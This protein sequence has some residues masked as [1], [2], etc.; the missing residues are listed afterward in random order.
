MRFLL[1]LC[2]L[3]T[4][5]TIFGQDRFQELDQHFQRLNKDGYFSGNILMAEGDSILF[6]GSY[7]YADVAAKRK[8]N[9]ESVFEL[10]SVS[11]QF[12]ATGIALLAED[13]KIDLDEPVATYLPELAAYPKITVRHLVHHVG[14]LADYMEFSEKHVKR[15]EFVTNQTVLD[16]FRDK[17]PKVSFKAGDHFEYSNS[18]YLILA[19][20]IERVSEQSFGD[21][22]TARIFKPLGM[23]SSSVY[24]RRYAPRTIENYAHGHVWTGE[25]YAI[26]DSLEDLQFVVWL[27]GVVGDGM[28]NSTLDD[29]WKW[30]R[31]FAKGKLDTALLFQPGLEADSSSTGYA[32]GLGVRNHPD[33]GR[34]ISHSGGWPGYNTFTYYFPETDRTL[35][36]LRN[37]NGG[38]SG[39]IN[40]LRNSIRTLFELPLETES[41]HPLTTT[42]VDLKAAKEYVGTYAVVPEFKLKFFIKKDKFFTQATNQ[43]A[44]ELAAVPD[45]E[46]RFAI[47]EVDAEIQF[48]RD[49]KGKVT[50]LT[51]FQAGQEVP[52][53]RE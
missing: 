47:T 26:P 14:G 6:T 9:R 19:S 42:E 15:K 48:N 10:A 43:P 52:A 30:N 45:K 13:G 40:I 32:F 38:K 36:L 27:D 51:L 34:T 2:L 28:V 50:S 41:L 3:A 33:Y 53:Q 16:V 21:F 18:G 44:F 7:G 35:I 37:D 24:R 25:N 23:E 11:K 17:K 1:S 4:L 31:A 39:R 46:D 22:L 20:V 29:L 12:T 5:G 8:L 49:D